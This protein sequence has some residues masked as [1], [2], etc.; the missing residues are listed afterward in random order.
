MGDKPIQKAFEEIQKIDM[1]ISRASFY[2]WVAKMKK[3]STQ[4]ANLMTQD[5]ALDE[6]KSNI[7]KKRLLNTIINLGIHTLNDPRELV[8]LSPKDKLTLALTAAKELQAEEGMILSDIHHREK[9][10]LNK[11]MMDAAA[12]PQIIIEDNREGEV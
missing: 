4:L 1:N 5:L 7:E 10:D 9:I 3:T 6:A 11:E 8:K 12:R 2:R